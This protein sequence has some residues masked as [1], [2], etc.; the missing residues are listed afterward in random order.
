MQGSILFASSTKDQRNQR[1]CDGE[2]SEDEISV[3][4]HED[5][6]DEEKPKKKQRMKTRASTPKTFWSSLAK[7]NKQIRH[8]NRLKALERNE[9]RQARKAKIFGESEGAFDLAPALPKTI[10]DLTRRMK[11]SWPV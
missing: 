5:S 6:Q 11:S 9:R 8:E 1:I 10:L 4:D 7:T 3:D 2:N